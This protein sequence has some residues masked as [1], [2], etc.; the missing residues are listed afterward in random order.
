MSG[1]Y[2]QPLWAKTCPVQL[3]ELALMAVNLGCLPRQRDMA[4][5]FPFAGSTRS[6]AEHVSSDTHTEDTG[7][8]GHSH[9]HRGGAASGSTPWRNHTA[10][11]ADSPDNP[12]RLPEAEEG[13]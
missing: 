1:H 13:H 12:P 4:A 3:M 7:M 2:L 6:E 11:I 10:M 8:A 9:C 5:A